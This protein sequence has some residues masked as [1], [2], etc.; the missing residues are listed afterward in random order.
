MPWL[1]LLCLAAA[2]TGGAVAQPDYFGFVSIDCGLPGETGFLGN[3]TKLYFST[4]AGFIDAGVN[5]NISFD[6]KD[7]YASKSWNTVRSFPNGTRNCYTIGLPESGLKYLIRG[8]F[9]Y[10]NYDGLN[11]L[12]ILFDL[13]VGVNFWTT[14]NISNFADGYVW[15][16]IVVVPENFVQVCLVNTGFGTPFINTLELR[17]LKHKLYPQANETH[18]LVLVQR[19]NYGPSDPKTLFRYPDDPHDR[20]WWT[21]DNRIDWAEIKTDLVVTN[22]DDP[23]DTPTAVAQTA[24][25]PRNARSNIE[26]SLPLSAS[27][28]NLI[29]IMHF[30]ELN[31][32]TGNASRQF[33]INVNGKPW[34][35]AY[36]PFFL[37]SSVIFN[38]EPTEYSQFN[39]SIS[40]LASSTLPPIINAIELYSVI[41]TTNLSTDAQDASTITAI[42]KDYQVHKN[43]M[44]DPCFPSSLVWAGLNC[45]YDVSKPPII[46]SINL[47]FSGLSGV[48]SPCFANIKNLQ[49][50]DLSSNNLIGS[51]P[52]ELSQLPSLTLLDISNNQLNGSIPSG[53][54]KRTQDGSLVLRYGNNPSL[55]TRSSCQPAQGRSKRVII[56]VALVIVVLVIVLSVG[57]L[58]FFL[59]RRKNR[60]MNNSEM[61][62]STSNNNGYTY[63]SLP[64][65]NRQ[66]TYKELEMITKNFRQVLGQGGFGCVYHG[67]LENGI[68]VAVKLRSHS[69]DQGVREFLVEAQVLA[70]IHHKNLVTMIGYCKE[71]EQMALVY[72]YMPEGNLEEHITGQDRNGRYLTWRQ[73]LR[74]ALES[75][76]GLEYLHKGCNPPLIHRD[77]KATNVLLNTALEAKI[78]DF[79]MS[80]TFSVNTSVQASTFTL[81]GTPGYVDPEYQATMQP[82]TRSDVYS[83]GVVL[84]ELITGKPAI[85]RD[86]EPITVIRWARERLSR[87][88]IEAVVDTRLQGDYDVNTAWKA[89]EIAFKCTDQESLQRPTM[90]EVVVQLQECLQLAEDRIGFEKNSELYSGSNTSFEMDQQKYKRDLAMDN[91]P[92]AR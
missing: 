83:F 63:S 43:W 5:Y 53:L 44:G 14:V 13:Y 33:D 26:F 1:L 7:P 72:E 47:S 52:D 3:N 90:T 56:I 81:V 51:I 45:S 57:V 77:V 55:C 65:D 48:I 22:A 27:P 76:Q 75:S 25:T 4:D 71:G 15:E 84:L 38:I 34:R 17:P 29:Y 8:K 35:Q 61:V 10:G 69:S 86:P 73:R 91:G 92:G 58:L 39:V 36:K 88:D 54:F 70:R 9:W 80:K 16:A 67:I 6:Y 21:P 11:R 30:S 66:F 20:M 46:I 85:V 49:Y 40:A 12:P 24:I 87:G 62:S 2:A 41:S 32:L 60:G 78:A 23:F 50:L 19:F 79:G 89:A 68:Q 28:L 59:Q 82:S 37:V 18:G 31:L 42:K 74:I 64:L